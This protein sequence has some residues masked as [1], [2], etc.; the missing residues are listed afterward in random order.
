M[1]IS[2]LAP[3]TTWKV[4]Q[5]RGLYI[6]SLTKIRVRNEGPMIVLVCDNRRTQ[7]TTSQAHKMGFALWKKADLC[8]MEANDGVL[9]NGDFA[10]EFVVLTIDGRELQIEAA[11]ARQLGLSLLRRSDYVDDFQIQHKIR[12]VQ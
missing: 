2:I 6:P 9:Y 1:S 11:A 5:R 10:N 3:N 8:V 12:I 4:E 7:L